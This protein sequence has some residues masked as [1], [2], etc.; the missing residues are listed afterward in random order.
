MNE[1]AITIRRLA[2][3]SLGALDS[4]LLNRQSGV[5]VLCHHA[6]ACRADD[7][8]RF[9]V[10]LGEF[11]KQVEYLGEHYR[12]VAAAD[13]EQ[14]IRGKKDLGSPSVLLTFDDGYRDLLLI[15]DYLSSLGVRPLL[16]V[17]SRG[18]DMDRAETKTARELLSFSEIGELSVAGWDIGSH[19]A[20]HR[21]FAGLSSKQIREEV[22]DSRLDLEAALGLEVRYFAY[23]KGKYSDEVLAAV[24][25]A[26]YALG[27]T[28]DDGV[29]SSA[30]D[31]MKV[32]RIGIDR[33]H[34]FTEFKS[35][36]SPSVINFRF[37]TKRL[38]NE[39]YLGV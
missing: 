28:M 3:I 8:W 26:G 35:V 31:P 34:S 25:E 24:R 21:S 9:S 12:F 18:S 20:T 5:V 11:K 38:I 4:W 33:T 23:P 37:V 32:P 1:T 2:Y 15:K 13:L 17:L 39:K 19:G 10:D 29:V 27:F 30:T 36:A 6:I 14:H 16:F 22:I 7:D